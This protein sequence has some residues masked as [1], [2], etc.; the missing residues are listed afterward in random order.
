MHYRFVKGKKI[1]RDDDIVEKT[2][3]EDNIFNLNNNILS[4]EEFSIIRA[5]RNVLFD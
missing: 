3:L 2:D 4:D 1:M 5:K